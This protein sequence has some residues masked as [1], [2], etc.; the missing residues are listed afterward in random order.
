MRFHHRL[1]A[2]AVLAGFLSESSLAQQRKLLVISVDGMDTRYL[3]D[4]DR[5]GLKIPTLRRLMAE[6]TTAQ[7][8]VGIVPTVTWPSHTT[9]IS[10][11][12]SEEH[13][14]LTNDQPGQPGQRWWFTSFLKAPTLWK[15]AHDKGLKTATVYWPVTVGATV[16]FNFPEFW[17]KRSEHEIEFAPIAE[18]STPGLL[19]KVAKVYPKFKRDL[20]D[21]EAGILAVRYLLEFERPDLTLVHIADLDSEAHEKGAFTAAAHKVLENQDRLIGQALEKLPA[22]TI[23]AVVSDHGFENIDKVVRPNAMLKAASLPAEAVVSNG[24]IGVK[25]ARAA[26]HFRTLA[27]KPSSVIAREVPMAEVR[28][29]AP[30]L[31]DWIAAFEPSAGHV[32]AAAQDGAPISEGN[33]T[34]THGLWPTRANYRA[35]FLLWGPGVKRGKLGEVSMLELGPTFA[36][37]LGL[38]LPGAKMA[39]LWPKLH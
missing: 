37:I 27:G 9:I 19:D 2:L 28:K 7:G 36:E 12:P 15:I 29:M 16:D 31:K 35:S 30:M 17:V 11:V 5:L 13:G 23:V 22:G 38:P 3:K 1:A 24:L 34:G 10:G 21:D 20:W 26:A 8:V 18:R 6:G 4:A 25:D 39:S 14:I 32:A 33:H